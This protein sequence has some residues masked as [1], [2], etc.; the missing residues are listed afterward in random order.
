MPTT[1]G[2][3]KPQNLAIERDGIE[4]LSIVQRVCRGLPVDLNEMSLEQ[5]ENL[6]ETLSLIQ[7]AFHQAWEIDG[8]T[9]ENNVKN[10]A[11][12][13]DKKLEAIEFADKLYADCQIDRMF[14]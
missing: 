8:E 3:T 12:K 13:V 5:I 2:M 7:E 6:S 4:M 1:R 10:F 14:D 11:V 9:V